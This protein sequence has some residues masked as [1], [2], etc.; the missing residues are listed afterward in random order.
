VT[1]NMAV[2]R[3]A[4]T[5][6]TAV[7][8]KT[9]LLNKTGPTSLVLTRQGVPHI[10][11]TPAQVTDIA[12]GGYILAD[13]DVEPEVIVIATGS[14]VSISLEAANR[15]QGEGKA[16]RLVSMPSTDAFDA[17]DEA[18]REAV[19]PSAVRKRVAVE[20]AQVDYWRKYVGLDGKVVGMTTFGESAPGKVVMEYFGF[21]ADNIVKTVDSLL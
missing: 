5:V 20:A 2:W 21:T 14:E 15:L 16:V 12:R 17:Q 11:R 9:A 19:L 1:P 10:E 3:P 4:D 7:A 18:Y 13:C 6:E 8:W